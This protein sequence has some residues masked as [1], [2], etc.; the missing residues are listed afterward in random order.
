MALLEQTLAGIA[1]DI[2]GATRV[3]HQF[4]LDF[5][6]GGQKPLAEALAARGLE[7][8]TVVAALEKL[9]Q[10]PREERDWRSADA[11]TLIEHIL[12]RFHEKHREQLPEL[13]RLARRVEHVHA[14]RAGCPLGLAAHLSHMQQA[15]ESHMQKEEQ[16][17][18]PLLQA[19]RNQLAGGPIAVMQAEHEQHGDGLEELA[20]L[21]NDITPPP[22]ACV[23]WRALYTGLTQL[24]EE[25]MQHIHLENNVLFARAL[26]EA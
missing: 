7:A 1:C 14:E 12:Q 18:F 25:L 19:D 21:T 16:I 5:C 2:P 17:L 9:Q 20:R 13:I 26:A 24:R 11:G 8:T 10:Q 15:L 4:K 3:F 23:T 6:C 22:G